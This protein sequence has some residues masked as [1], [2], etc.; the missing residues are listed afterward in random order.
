MSYPLTAI[1]SDLHGNAPALE[2]AI[3]D[4]RRRGVRRFVCLG[5]IVGYGASPRHNLDLVTFREGSPD[6]TPKSREE[7]ANVAEILRAHPE[8]EIALGG[9]SD[10]RDP[11]A[12]RGLA[13]ARAEQVRRQ[14]IDLGAPAHQIRV[15]AFSGSPGGAGGVMQVGRGME[16]GVAVRVVE[17]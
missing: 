17:K 10:I 6:P 7:L 8:T 2:T 13:Q 5:D 16:Q 12:N 11:G 15:E 4:A 9:Y 1:I 3:E 14:L